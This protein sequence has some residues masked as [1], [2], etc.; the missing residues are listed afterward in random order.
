MTTILF[1]LLFA[2]VQEPP[3]PAAAA[4]SADDEF[5]KAVFFGKKFF[6]LGEFT[7]SYEQF[8]KADAIKADQPAVLYDMALVLAKAGRYSES[9]VKLD[10]Y[11]KLFPSGEEKPLATKLQLELEFQRELQKKRQADEAYADLFIRE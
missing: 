10:R 8:A 1:L 9:Q 11:L 7:S 2:F 5:Q 3:A 6:D 4:P